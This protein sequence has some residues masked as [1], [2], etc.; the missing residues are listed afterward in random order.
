MVETFILVFFVGVL[1]KWYWKLVPFMVAFIGQS[2]L[3]NLNILVFRDGWNLFD[4]M[5]IYFMSLTAFILI[6]KYSLKPKKIV[7]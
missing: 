1:K 2:L 6:E 5:L 7:N 4:T 3:V